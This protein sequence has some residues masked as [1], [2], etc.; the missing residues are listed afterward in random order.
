MSSSGSIAH[1]MAAATCGAHVLLSSLP[2]AARYGC[3]EDSTR[4]ALQFGD[5]VAG[6][7]VS[8]SSAC[9]VRSLR[10]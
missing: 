6:G 5:G 8:F 1:E 2:G 10:F 4:R 9:W 3:A 7:L